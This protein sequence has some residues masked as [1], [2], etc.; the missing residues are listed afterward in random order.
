MTSWNAGPLLRRERAV[1]VNTLRSVLSHMPARR[2]PPANAVRER[3][4]NDGT[5]QQRHNSN[6]GSLPSCHNYHNL[7][8]SLHEDFSITASNTAQRRKRR[9]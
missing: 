6:G 1:E 3:L 8:P 2:L 5:R 9:Q 7:L 4:K